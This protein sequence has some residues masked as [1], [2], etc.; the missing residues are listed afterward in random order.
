MTHQQQNRFISNNLPTN[1]QAN[2]YSISDYEDLP[3]L[4][5]EEAVKEII[6][7]IPHVMDYVATAMEKHKQHSTLLTSDESAAIYLYTMAKTEFY[8]NLNSALR[9]PNRQKLNPWLSFL[10]I[11][12]TALKKLPSTK[13][14]ISRG[15][16]YDATSEF[17]EDEIYTYWNI[18]SCTKDLSAAEMY[19]PK[20]GSLL[21]I[22]A[23]HG[24]DVSMFSAVPDEQEVILMPG[25][26]M[27]AKCRTTNLL[28]SFFIIH[29]EEINFET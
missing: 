26:R 17:I 22:E 15:V 20:G 24:K 13:A 27:R 25:T 2:R 19:V 5:L 16:A 21:F 8:S 23:I 11:L 1:Q 7:L 6:Q 4:P 10:K 28:Q 29:L 9:D 3:L 14:I 18:S 12:I